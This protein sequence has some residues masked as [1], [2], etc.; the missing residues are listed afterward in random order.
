MPPAIADVCTNRFTSRSAED[1]DVDLKEKEDDL[2][3]NHEVEIS[4]YVIYYSSC[5]KIF[6]S[7]QSKPA[8]V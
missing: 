3:E 8:T 5:Y 6:H 4:N 2:G 7:L 1:I